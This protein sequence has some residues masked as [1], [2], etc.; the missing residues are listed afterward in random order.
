ME[1][2]GIILSFEDIVNKI[3]TSKVD[4]LE[5]LIFPQKLLIS[6]RKARIVLLPTIM[7]KNDTIKLR[8]S[9]IT[10]P[11]PGVVGPNVEGAILLKNR[12]VQRHFY[13]PKNF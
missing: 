3:H 9:L 12:L 1:K 2:N 11:A 13:I 10:P 7:K 5:R 6:L 8:Y 4:S